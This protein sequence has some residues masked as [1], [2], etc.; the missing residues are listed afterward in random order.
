MVCY[1]SLGGSGV[2]AAELARGLA[3][4]GHSVHLIATARPWRAAMSPRLHF[5]RVDVPLHPVYEHAPYSEAVASAI[6]DVSRRHQVDLVQVHYAV[7]HA[8]SALMAR[9]VLAAERARAALRHLAARQRRHHGRRR[10]ERPIGDVVRHRRIRRCHRAVRVPVPRGARPARAAGRSGHRGRPQLRRHRSLRAVAQ[11]RPERLDRLDRLDATRWS[12]CTSPTSVRSSGSAI[13]WRCWRRVRAAVPARLVLVGDGPER[14]RAGG[15]RRC[16]RAGRPCRLPRPARRL[17]A[18]AAPAPTRSSCP[19]S[20]RASAWPRSRRRAPRVPVFAYRVGGLPEVVA[21]GGGAAGRAVRHRRHG[22]R[23]DRRGHRTGS[24][25]GAGPGR[26]GARAGPLP[27]RAGARSLRGVLPAPPGRRGGGGGSVTAARAAAHTIAAL[28]LSLTA[29]PVAASEPPMHAGELAHAL[30][31]LA[32][33]G[34]VLYVAAHPDDENT[35]LL[36]YLAG[37]RNMTV[38]YL[39]MTRGGGGQNLIGGEQ[40][41]LLDVIRTE[42]LLSARRLDGGDA[43]LHPHARLRLLEERGRDDVE[44]GARRGAGRRGVGHPHLPAG[45]RHHALRRGA[46]QPRPPHRVG[47]PGARGVRRRRR[48]GALPGPAAARRE[49]VEGGAAAAELRLVARRAG[50]ARRGRARRRRL[51]SA[52]SA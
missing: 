9:Q 40:G 50:A 38:A 13:C 31:R 12:C 7:P 35:A 42:E 36:A 29:A 49:G 4:R 3:E 10:S 6:V 32:T 43:A 51:R 8:A 19:A 45:R 37:A 47:D 46:A 48:S 11:P 44:V 20:A 41:D 2:I 22:A 52:H 18:R 16:A 14:A 24:R 5:H 33:T 15:A 1:P 39:S 26:A 17:S 34:R 25:R 23:G 30:D 27:A 21:G 28:A